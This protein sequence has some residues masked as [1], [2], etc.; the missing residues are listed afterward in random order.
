MFVQ[1]TC[2]LRIHSRP[3]PYRLRPHTAFYSYVNSNMC[4]HLDLNQGPRRYKLRAL[5][6]EL[7]A[8]ERNIMKTCFHYF[9]T[10]RTQAVLMGACFLLN[11]P[12]VYT[13]NPQP[14]RWGFCANT[15]TYTILLAREGSCL[16]LA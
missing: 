2:A 16:T 7:W 11:R 9:R 12:S 5:P 6:T 15:S 8:Q 3:L 1:N 13:Q 4:A 10:Q 14:Y